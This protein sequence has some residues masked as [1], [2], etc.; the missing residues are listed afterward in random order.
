MMVVRFCLAVAYCAYLCRVC[1]LPMVFAHCLWWMHRTGTHT[2]HHRKV[3]VCVSLHVFTACLLLLL[4]CYLL[5]AL[6]QC[7]TGSA[8]VGKDT[9]IEQLCFGCILV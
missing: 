8:A 4:S 9:V 2:M 5:C 3:S 7:V 1:T 6:Q